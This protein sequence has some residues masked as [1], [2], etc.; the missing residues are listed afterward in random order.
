MGV[1]FN[2]QSTGEEE[3]ALGELATE[4]LHERNGTTA[5]CKE[6]VLAEHFVGCLEE[7]LL[8]LCGEVRGVKAIVDIIVL[9]GDLGAEVL[10]AV[11]LQ[12]LAEPLLAVFFLDGR[13][14]TEG[15][16]IDHFFV[17]HVSRVLQVG[18][19]RLANHIHAAL[20]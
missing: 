18:E 3:V 7:F 8:E 15:H 6:G 19:T 12:D 13:G 10:G 9:C 1:A 16:L 5:T 17:N 14:Q 4:D 20:P 2:E 11:L